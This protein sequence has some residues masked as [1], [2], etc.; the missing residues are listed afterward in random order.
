M[1]RV[2]RMSDRPVQAPRPGERVGV[3]TGRWLRAMLWLLGMAL[4][5]VAAE[6]SD[7]IPVPGGM[8]YLPASAPVQDPARLDLL[9]HFHGHPPLMASNFIRSGLEGALVVLNERGLS[10]AYARPYRDPIAFESL[11]ALVRTQAG[12]RRGTS[13]R[14]GRLVV[15]SFSA[16]Y[17]AVRELLKQPVVHQITDLILADSLYAGHVVAGDGSRVPDPVQMAGFEQWAVRAARGEV[18]MVV[19]YSDLATSGYA[20][21]GETAG[22]LLAAAGL[23]P[24]E[25]PDLGPDGRWCLATADRGRLHV[26]RMLGDTA[27][28]HMEH[29]RR[30]A[31]A[32]RLIR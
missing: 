20:S 28:A 8:L 10:S 6:L 12:A 15:S 5:S 1:L 11:L 21:T 9:V 27:D 18:G 2:V 14:E 7:A 3:R 23:Q 13:V 25:A 16:G 19:T 4:Q 22:R 29:L 17:G 24:V 31:A 30:I 32:W 26:R